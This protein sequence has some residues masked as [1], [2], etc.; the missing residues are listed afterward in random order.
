M[1]ALIKQL[2]VLLGG[3]VLLFLV[4]FPQSGW[5]EAP[6]GHEQ[7]Q[8][9]VHASVSLG[10]DYSYG[11]GPKAPRL[12]VG[13]DWDGLSKDAKWFIKGRLYQAFGEHDGVENPRDAVVLSLLQYPNS[14]ILDRGLLHGFVT[15]LPFESRGA[16]FSW[17]STQGAGL[18]IRPIQ[19]KILTLSGG[20]GPGFQYINPDQSATEVVFSFLYGGMAYG[21]LT[22]RLSY[23]TYFF[24][25]TGTP[26]RD[27]LLNISRLDYQLT[28]RFS[29]QIG[30]TTYLSEGLEDGFKDFI[31]H[32]RLA[33][34][35][36]LW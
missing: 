32:T 2:A 27:F 14:G 35:Y 12:F 31:G 28:R 15:A 25:A 29:A 3:L 8:E 10:P 30:V 17:R 24:G 13:T 6:T 5:T 19:S 20:V 9:Y 26:E 18:G 4:L 7:A 23:V 16:G 21:H 34:T 33:L 1:T 11:A 36:H 22:S